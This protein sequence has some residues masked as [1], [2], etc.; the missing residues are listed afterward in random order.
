M[1][2]D[3]KLSCPINDAPKRGARMLTLFRRHAGDT[4]S[5]DLTL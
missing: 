5:I 2:D 1:S 4:P 3:S